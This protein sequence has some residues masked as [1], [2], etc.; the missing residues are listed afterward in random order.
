MAEERER[1]VLRFIHRFSRTLSCEL[2]IAAQPPDPEKI[3]SPVYVWTGGR[4]KKKHVK[5]YRQWALLVHQRLA[6]QWQQSIL[7]ALGIPPNQM[8]LWSFESHRSP[9]LL[10][11]IP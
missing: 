3:L 11:K 5:E 7:Y 8:E 10:K 1:K 9:K 6:D 4:P 2:H